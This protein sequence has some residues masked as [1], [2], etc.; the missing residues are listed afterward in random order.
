MKNTVTLEVDLHLCIAYPK[1]SAKVY[2]VGSYID[3]LSM[4]EDEAADVYYCLKKLMSLLRDE[5][6][7][8]EMPECNYMYEV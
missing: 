4:Q 7:F 3:L 2:N 6:N 8:E 5:Y 1:E